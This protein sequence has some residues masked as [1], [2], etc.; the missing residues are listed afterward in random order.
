MLS[1]VAVEE[2]VVVD[3]GIANVD[4]DGCGS[5]GSFAADV[6]AAT[7][8]PLPTAAASHRESKSLSSCRV[9]S[10]VGMVMEITIFDVERVDVARS[11]ST[12]TMTIL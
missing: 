12:M 6:A 11:R 1:V 8:L 5:S 4:E 2:E 7:L 9:N 10:S 3:D